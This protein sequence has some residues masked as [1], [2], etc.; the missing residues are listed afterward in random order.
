MGGSRD[1]TPHLGTDVSVVTVQLQADSLAKEYHSA[2][3][4]QMHDNT[5]S[6]RPG[7]EVH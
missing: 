6:M 3:S 7:M 2:S 5:K 4:A 1:H